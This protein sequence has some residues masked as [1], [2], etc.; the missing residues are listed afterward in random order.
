MND[1]ELKYQKEIN[2]L[3]E[4]CNRSSVP[5]DINKIEKAGQNAFQLLK[6]SKWESGEP[7][8]FHSIDVAKVVADDIGVGTDSIVASLLHNV[9]EGQNDNDELIQK[10][11]YEF[12]DAAFELLEGLFKINSIDTVNISVHSENFRRLLMTLSGDI[13][14]VLIKIADRLIDMRSLSELPHDLQYKYA[15]ETS[16][17]YAPL[18]HRMGLYNVKSELEDLSLKYLRPDDYNIIVKKLEETTEERRKF[19]SEFVKPIESKLKYR[20]FNF[21]MKART[22][23]I[24]SIWNKMNKSGVSFEEVFDLFAIRVILDSKPENE[25]SD[26]WQVYSIV[27]DEYQPNTER[28]RD[29]ISIPKSNGYESL[30]TTVMGPHGKW[31]EVQIRTTR[32]DDIA[33]RGLAAHWK[34]KGGKGNDD[35]DH[36]LSNIRE[37]LENP[38]GDPNVLLEEFKTNIYEDELFVFT[39]KGDLRKLTAGATILDFAYDIHSDLGDHCVGGKV[40]NR[41]VTIKHKLKNGDQVSIETSNNQ[42]PKLDW[43][44]FVATSKA[45]SRIKSSLN[46]EK[47]REAE[48]GKEIVKRKF[49]NWKIDYTDEVIRTLLS[50]LNMKSA[51]DMYYAVAAGKIEALELKSIIKGKEEEEDKAKDVLGEL[52]PKK[53]IEQLSFDNSEEFLVIDNNLKNV[54]YKLAQCCNPIFGDKIFGF[55]TIREGI[56]IHREN[57]PNAKQM[58]ERYPYRFIKAKWHETKQN[59][60]FQATIHL[61]G[62]DR[63]GIIGDISYII[64]KDVGVQMRSINIDSKNGSFEGVLRVYVNDIEHLEFLMNKLQSIKGIE[65]VTRGDF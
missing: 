22:K 1:L 41:K 15:T 10:L 21:D 57:C 62:S 7:I 30:H 3:L 8:I 63:L 19:V 16:Y 18:A 14:V 38:E 65:F 13:R 51:Q 24:Y 27:T 54:H 43:L 55:I 48:N 58:R 61:V 46:E 9:F 60:S 34:Y 20:S 50:A 40:N 52:L 12:G 11:P 6:D 53:E 49:K 5:I 31:V 17:L 44:D 42:K 28:M 26:C 29:W 36:W 47:K 2:K 45:K 23:S 56:K 59:N 39:P 33:E 37:I 25:K 35:L 64:A 32:M 4:I